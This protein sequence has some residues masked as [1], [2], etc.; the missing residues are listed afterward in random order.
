MGVAVIAA[1]GSGQAGP[2]GLLVIALLGVAVLF[3]G[4]SMA[5]HLRRVPPSFDPPAAGGPV[6]GA[7]DSEPDDTP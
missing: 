7:A 1:D 3:L 5:K 6:G 2:L 4:R